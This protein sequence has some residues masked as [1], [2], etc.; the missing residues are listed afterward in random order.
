MRNTLVIIV[1]FVLTF[2]FGSNIYAT[3]TSIVN[4][5]KAYTYDDF[6]EDVWILKSKYKK[7]ITVHTIGK[8][9]FGRK[10]YALQVGSGKNN[11]LITGAH[12]G[13]EWITSLLT[14]KMA[15]ETAN[16][17]KMGNDFLQSF[18]I[19]F[20]PM[21][22][23]DGVT[24][25]QGDIHKFS[26]FTKRKIIKM[27]NGLKDFTRW[28]SNGAGVDL[29]RQ[30]PAGWESLKYLSKKPSYKNYKGKK[31]IEAEEVQAIV[32]LT[33]KIKPV[34]AVSYHS[35]GQEI[36]WQYKNGINEKRDKKIAKTI[37]QKTGYTLGVPKKDAI[38]G[39]YTDWFITKYHR[40]AFTIEIC[41]L[42]EETNPPLKTFNEEWQ[43]N[44]HIPKTLV[45][46]GEK[47]LH[48]KIKGESY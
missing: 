25:Q 8:S 3:S 10:L 26:F 34:L 45:E 14:M 19:W 6:Q 9:E 1:C 43:R 2:A 41:P 37:A 31:P 29:N 36:F 7:E 47:L 11:L 30:Y 42:V 20:V 24:I 22:N 33:E 40:P 16:S 27:N 15:E 44:R 48:K 21:I 32:N 28:K 38:G 4:V 23:P 18:S 17:L 5:N 13:R 39:G 46:E 35:S 12:H